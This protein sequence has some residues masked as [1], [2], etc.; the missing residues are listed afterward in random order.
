MIRL[1]RRLGLRSTDFLARYTVPFQM[2]G[3]GLPGIRL[4]TDENGTC[5]QR[6]G[7][8][9]CGVYAE[10]PT[11]CRYYP[12]ALLALREKGSAAV[13]QQYS[14]VKEDHCRGHLEAR[15]F[16]AGDYRDEQGAVAATT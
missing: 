13:R 9:G 6:N 7:D 11:L 5:L 15:Q 4:T 1:K 8:E 14:L 3:D 12:L 2:D 16:R 10:R